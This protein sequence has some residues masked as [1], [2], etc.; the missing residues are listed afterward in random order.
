METQAF[1]VL[2]ATLA[3]FLGP[4][5]YPIIQQLWELVIP[6]AM[7]Y[8]GII[9]IVEKD[10]LGSALYTQIVKMLDDHGCFI[11]LHWKEDA[12]R[13]GSGWYIC[14]KYHIFGYMSDVSMHSSGGVTINGYQKNIEAFLRDAKKSSKS[15]CMKKESDEVSDSNTINDE[16]AQPEISSIKTMMFQPSCGEHMLLE[17]EEEY[18][19]MYVPAQS[20]IVDRLQQQYEKLCTLEGVSK[21]VMAL[22][23]GP[24]GTSK[25]DV[26]RVLAARYPGSTLVLRYSPV[27]YGTN[28]AS[29]QIRSAEHLKPLIVI[30]EEF[31]TV[32]ETIHSENKTARIRGHIAD[33]TCKSEFVEV[34][35]NMSRQNN[36][37]VI[38]TS[39]KPLKWFQC[40][41]Y[42]YA[43]RDSR[44]HYQ[45]E[46]LALS[47]QDQL[48]VIS[49]AIKKYRL[50]E[51]DVDRIK[52]STMV[53][54]G[55]IDNYM[56]RC[57]LC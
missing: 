6:L 27:V 55:S 34:L 18:I 8:C 23:T 30:I 40:E 24:P 11:T 52:L 57:K 39:N 15:S 28:F 20:A 21:S 9:N 46:L 56:R 43:V 4:L 3:G 48:I 37:F 25:S 44:M 50:T 38:F 51:S 42:Q 17:T 29:I 1:V 26:G 33:A 53:T 13:G 36:L 45:L 12:I 49:E 22:I 16:I 14:K 32:L 41:L 2:F 19:P 54:V 5:L 10:G 31:D 47:E 35:D 7:R